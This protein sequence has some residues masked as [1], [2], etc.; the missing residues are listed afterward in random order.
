MPPPANCSNW[1]SLT[2]IALE[3][4]NFDNVVLELIESARAAGI[5]FRAVVADCFYRDNLELEGLLTQRKIPYVLAHC[6]I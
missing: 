4:S 5:P 3:N 2:Y 6:R 1:S